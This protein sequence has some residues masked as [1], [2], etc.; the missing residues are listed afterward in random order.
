[1]LLLYQSRSLLSLSSMRPFLATNPIRFA[2]CMHCP[3]LLPITLTRCLYLSLPLRRWLLISTGRSTMLPDVPSVSVFWY[4]Y[5]NDILFIRPNIKAIMQPR[6]L[7]NVVSASGTNIVSPLRSSSGPHSLLH[8]SHP[9]LFHDGWH[10]RA[11]SR[12]AHVE[13]HW[14]PFW[15]LCSRLIFPRYAIACRAVAMTMPCLTSRLRIDTWVIPSH[16]AVLSVLICFPVVSLPHVHCSAVQFLCCYALFACHTHAPG[17]GIRFTCLE[18]VVWMIAWLLR[19]W[20]NGWRLY[21]FHYVSCDWSRRRHPLGGEKV[22]SFLCPA[23]CI[24]HSFLLTRP[25]ANASTTL[26]IVLDAVS[27]FGATLV[28]SLMSR[29]WSHS[30][31]C[32]SSPLLSHTISAAEARAVAP[33]AVHDAESDAEP[34]AR[35][36]DCHYVTPSTGVVA[37]LHCVML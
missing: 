23:V 29:D 22:S 10:R 25:I 32:L 15:T 30:R 18:Y 6:I 17:A 13:R 26:P 27:V 34:S 31:L 28:S 20:L 19:Q 5:L 16:Q 37:V 8:F 35:E 9:L 36:G 14:E 1:M 7:L 21:R 12:P 24:I 33:A 3:S 4:T 2:G 11:R